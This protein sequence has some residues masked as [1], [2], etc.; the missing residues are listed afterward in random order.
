MAERATA[1]DVH[2]TP[3]GD[4]I[5]H[6]LTADCVCGPTLEPVERDDGTFGWLY[7]HHSLDGRERE[8]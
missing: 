2:V 1:D 8:E 4:L 6:P 3:R 5:D 7:T